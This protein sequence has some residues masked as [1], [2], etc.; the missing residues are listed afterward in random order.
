MEK[1]RGL[2]Y[3]HAF[4]PN[5]RFASLSLSLSLSLFLPLIWG[6]QTHK[7]TTA[8]T[9]LFLFCFRG[10]VSLSILLRH[11]KSLLRRGRRGFDVLSRFFLGQGRM[12][13]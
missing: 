6:R 12:G 3:K 1:G 4:V 5:A 8:A 7:C 13:M 9:R 10:C 2:L 11:K